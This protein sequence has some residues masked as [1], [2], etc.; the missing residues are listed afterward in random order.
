MNISLTPELKRWVE[1]RVASGQYTSA[2]EVVREALRLFFRYDAAQAREIGLLNERIAE[3]L[4]HLD[5]CEGIPGDE[6]RRE[7]HRRLTARLAAN[8]KRTK[9]Q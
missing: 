1:E 3:G 4:A 5:R 6:A 9:P 8:G 7:S 2:S